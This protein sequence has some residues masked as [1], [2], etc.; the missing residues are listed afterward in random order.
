MK[1]RILISL[2]IFA[3]VSVALVGCGNNNEN[4]PEK[5]ETV[6]FEVGK[7]LG[8]FETVDLNGNPVNQEILKETDLTLVQVWGTYCSPCQSELPAM[9]ALADHYAQSN[10]KFVGIILDAAREDG[11]PKDEQIAQAHS[12]LEG[13]QATYLQLLPNGTMMSN[14]QLKA[15]RALPTTF[16]VDKEGNIYKNAYIGAKSLEDWKA[17]IDG[18]LQEKGLPV[19][20]GEPVVSEQTQTEPEPE[21]TTADTT[22]TPP[23]ESIDP[24]D[25]Q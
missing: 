20:T 14:T 6:Q 12:L 5:S 1:K 2:V 15:V 3:V 23:T 22:E 18:V 11:S 4:R 8:D 24:G 13:A 7:P 25:N 21:G 10:V 17:V 19:P 16:F 9:A